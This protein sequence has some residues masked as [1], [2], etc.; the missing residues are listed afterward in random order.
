MVYVEEAGQVFRL[1]LNG[2]FY[3]KI[4]A[5]PYILQ[6]T[7]MNRSRPLLK[8]DSMIMTMMMTDDDYDDDDDDAY[9][10]DYDDD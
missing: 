3:P 4:L 1:V 6:S 10:D 8:I 9:D 2:V 7:P 5:S